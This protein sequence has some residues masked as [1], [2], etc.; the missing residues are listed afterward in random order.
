MTPSFRSRP[1]PTGTLEL[2]EW[3]LAAGITTV[4]DCS[5][6]ALGWYPAAHVCRIHSSIGEWSGGTNFPGR[7][8]QRP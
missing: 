3:I 6:T 2:R 4:K 7:E 1:S 8:V 5:Q